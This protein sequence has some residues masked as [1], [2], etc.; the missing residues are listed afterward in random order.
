VP[1]AEQA[2]NRRRGRA[3]NRR[4]QASAAKASF[5]GSGGCGIRTRGLLTPALSKVLPP[6]FTRVLAV[7]NER[8]GR[9]G[10]LVEQGRTKATETRTE[11]TTAW[12]TACDRV[13]RRPR[14]YNHEQARSGKEPAPGGEPFDP[15]GLRWSTAVPVGAGDRA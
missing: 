10:L 13:R 7:C 9:L 14:S 4:G 11:T 15:K 12:V 2:D 8:R 5:R 6:L 1:S 3:E